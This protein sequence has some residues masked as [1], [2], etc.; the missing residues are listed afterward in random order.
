VIRVVSLKGN[1][2]ISDRVVEGNLFKQAED[3]EEAMKNLMNVRY[4]IKG[5]LSRDDI[6][7][8]PLRLCVNLF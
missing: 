3:V 5:K 4:D 8:I 2:S 7:I 1:I 6:G